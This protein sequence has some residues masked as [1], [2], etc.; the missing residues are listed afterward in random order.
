QLRRFPGAPRQY[1]IPS[2]RRRQGALRPHAERFGSSRRPYMDRDRRKLSTKG[3]Q[4]RRS[5]SAAPVSGWVES[6][7]ARNDNLAHACCTVD[8][9]FDA[10]VSRDSCSAGLRVILGAVLALRLLLEDLPPGPGALLASVR[11]PAS[12]LH[13]LCF[14][15]LRIYRFTLGRPEA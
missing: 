15:L 10:V 3:R 8:R 4:R 12:G 1:P 6:D 7:Y 13:P 9:R 5:R 2:E 11:P 14:D